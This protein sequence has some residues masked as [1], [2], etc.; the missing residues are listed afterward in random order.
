VA[1]DDPTRPGTPRSAAA[2]AGRASLS[3]EIRA[4]RRVNARLQREAEARGAA[5]GDLRESEAKFRAAFQTSPDAIN[6]NRLDG[7]YVDINEGF[8]Q[9]T[10]FTR[11]DVL[12]VSSRELEIWAV[13]EDRDRLLQGLTAHGVVENLESLFRCKD[14][15][16]KT[17][18]MSARIIQV[19]GQPHILSVTRD[20]TER[21]QREEALS[22]SEARYRMLVEEAVDGILLGAPD[23][24]I[25]G[26]NSRMLALAGRDHREL[27]GRPIGEIFTPRSLRSTPLRFDLLRQ[28]STVTRERDL[29]LPDGS[30]LP[31][32]MHTKRMDDG[33]YQSIIRDISQRRRAER[34]L[35][36]SE[37]RFRRVV[38]NAEAAIFV[39]DADG[40]FQLCGGLALGRM[41][42]GEGPLEGR[43]ALEVC[44]AQP[45][46]IAP[47]RRA[48][49][50]EPLHVTIR[51]G[52]LVLDTRLSPL[53]DEDRRL[54][55]VLGVATDITA[56]V[57]SEQARLALERQLLHAQKLESLGVMAGGIA[58]DFNNL[59]MVIMGNAEIA[60]EQFPGGSPLARH[61]EL[62]VRAAT[63]A[64][65]LTR[66]MLAYAGMGQF[67]V[68]P[69]DLNQIVQ[70]NV[71]LLGVAASRNVTLRL[72][73]AAELPPI[74]GDAAQLQQLTMNLVTNAAEAVGTGPG[75]VTLRTGLRDLGA[76]ALSR[77]RVEAKPAPGRFVCLEVADTGCGMDPET[78]ERLFD[79][80]FTTKFTGRGLGMAAALGIV[81]GHGG[82]IF[83]D[84]VPGAGTVIQVLLPGSDRPGAAPVASSTDLAAARPRLSG[85]V[86]VV[87]DEAAVRDTCTAMLEKLGLRVLSAG[88]GEAAVRLY[89]ERGGEIHAVLLDLTMPRMGGLACLEALQGIREDVKVILASGFSSEEIS[90]RVGGRCLAGMLQKPYQFSQLAGE[91]ARVLGCPP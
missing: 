65:D 52:D 77:S 5:E 68:A 84:S 40:V 79:P 27:V 4:L 31:V 35:S 2:P 22:A 45:E 90:G 58:H 20:I 7:V 57:R 26:A 43:S 78:L 62:V 59:L 74:Q 47:L 38:E 37:A 39:V 88:D 48:L 8:T 18:L 72:D 23:G 12:G 67:S 29:L 71:H 55:G 19:G 21:R 28:G 82:A 6:L 11:D 89:R 42:W 10:G 16:L 33:T 14:G 60:L 24:T 41:G 61:L 49:A 51:T 80:F 81:S 70:E 85:T 76:E 17:A 1:L 53:R 66:Q 56:R 69:V 36:A 34:A 25:S 75:T 63:Q 83:I 64:A 3:E 50:G 87:D 32:E 13:P 30:P 86:L 15:R 91:L 46:V 44:R 73:L 54:G 9:L